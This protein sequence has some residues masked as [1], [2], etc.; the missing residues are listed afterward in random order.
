MQIIKVDPKSCTRWA[1]ADRSGFEFG[2]VF[3]LAQDIIANGQVEPVILRK[4]TIPGFEYEVIAGSRRWKA[5]LEAGINL[6]G[7]VQELSDEQASVVLI[8]ENQQLSICD[9]SKGL[10]YSKLL[11][12]KKTTRA[13]LAKLAGCSPSKLD[14]FLTFERIPATIWEA[15]GNPS[16]VSS[17]SAATIL[18]LSQ[19]GAKYLSALIHLAE[20]IRKGAGSRTLEQKVLK[21][22]NHKGQDIG[23]QEHIMLPS[24]KIIATWARSGIQFA[25]DITFDKEEF[26]KIVVD[27]FQKTLVDNSSENE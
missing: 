5:C 22:V 9:Y 1:F 17:R 23:F 8:K 18:A 26:E 7:I 21:A 6:K 25:K 12:E 27:Y 10:Y 14:N 11:A 15:V 19:K 24:G 16:R 20:D 4:S 2:D 3:E 13:N